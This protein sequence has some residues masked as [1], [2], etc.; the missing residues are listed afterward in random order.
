[1]QLFS[2]HA[3]MQ[4]NGNIKQMPISFVLMSGK[5]SK[6]Y[7]KVFSRTKENLD[8]QLKVKDVIL[9]FETSVW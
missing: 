7:K 1:M 2:I 4:C 8:G 9:D 3:F 5:R 6:D